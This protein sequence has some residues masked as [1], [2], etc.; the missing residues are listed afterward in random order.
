[1]HL[2]AAVDHVQ[3]IHTSTPDSVDPLCVLG[4][5]FSERNFVPYLLNPRATMNARQEQRDPPRRRVYTADEVTSL[6]EDDFDEPCC[7]GSD[8]D[9]SAEELL[10]SDNDR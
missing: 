6:M 10:D 5:F 2:H 3:S 9:L 7:L 8:D 4:A 1:M